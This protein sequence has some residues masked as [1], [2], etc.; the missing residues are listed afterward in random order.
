VNISFPWPVND[1]TFLDWAVL[2]VLLI[3]LA[4][5]FLYMMTTKAYLRGDAPAGDA[6]G[7]I[8]VVR[9]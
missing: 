4:V 3:V 1:N 2:I 8:K 9:G 5:G 6:S 7:P